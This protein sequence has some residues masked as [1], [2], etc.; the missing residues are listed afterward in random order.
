MKARL[1]HAIDP[2][3][4]RE[5]VSS[6][7]LLFAVSEE[8]K[9]KREA[10]EERETRTRGKCAEKLYALF[11]IRST[12]ERGKQNKDKTELTYSNLKK[13]RLFCVSFHCHLRVSPNGKL[14]RRLYPLY[15]AIQTIIFSPAE[16]SFRVKW[17]RREVCL[18]KKIT[19]RYNGWAVAFGGKIIII[20][21]SLGLLTEL[22]N[23]EEISLKLV[24]II[25]TF[26]GS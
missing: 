7:Q 10:S 26:G 20:N 3:L 6:L 5:D 19:T 11:V 23:R 15:P 9:D 14:T 13:T 17:H 25:M 18:C 2:Y 22:E 8:T 1:L 16:P 4:S 24:M 12:K 21:I